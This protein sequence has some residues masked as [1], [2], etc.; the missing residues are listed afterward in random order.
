MVINHPKAK[1][2]QTFAVSVFPILNLYPGDF[3]GKCVCRDKKEY[4]KGKKGYFF[5]LL[6][7]SFHY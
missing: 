1:S 3:N 6:I 2:I 5:H 4:T 7:S